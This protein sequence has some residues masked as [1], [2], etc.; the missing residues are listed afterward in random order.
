MV[1]RAMILFP[2]AGLQRD[3]EHLA[4]ISFRNRSIRILPRSYAKSLCTIIES[5]STGS[6]ATST[7]SLT[8]GETRYPAR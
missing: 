1:S 2:I 3:L 6:P 4:R 8:M 7:S 5:A